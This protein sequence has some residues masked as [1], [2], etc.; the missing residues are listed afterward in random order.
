[1][2]ELNVGEQVYVKLKGQDDN[3]TKGQVQQQVKSRSYDVT[4]NDRTYRRNQ[5][6]IKPANI[7]PVQTTMNDQ[8]EGQL[9]NANGTPQKTTRSQSPTPE[10]TRASNSSL[11]YQPSSVSSPS[12]KL[13][14][15]LPITSIPL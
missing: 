5:L 15:E 4:V 13:S 8:S 10:A 6:H 11:E 2:P 9:R 3:K 12:S 1:M 7:D 14:R